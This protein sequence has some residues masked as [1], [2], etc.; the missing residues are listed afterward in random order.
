MAARLETTTV[1][2]RPQRI[3]FW[4]LLFSSVVMS[5]VLLRMR[6]RAL[7]RLLASGETMPLNPPAG[8]PVQNVT[9]MMANDMDGSLQPGYQ[10][11]ALPV[12][13]NARAHVIL[14]HL[15]LNYARPNSKHP[16]AANKGVNEIFFITLPL[17]ANQVLPG[18]MAVVDLSGSFVDAHPSGIEP[19]TLTLLSIIAT[20]HANFPQIAQVRFLVDGQQRD[21]LAGHADLTRVYLASDSP[22][23]KHL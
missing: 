22:G 21:T 7:D 9:M 19:E 14:Q 6:E 18:T 5:V 13:A 20:L 2:S 8:T 10:N 12:D 3:L 4:I 15:I 1:I 11:L 23:V 17:E 16:I